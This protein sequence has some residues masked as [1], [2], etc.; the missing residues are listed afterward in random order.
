MQLLG[1]LLLLVGLQTAGQ[2]VPG[3]VVLSASRTHPYVGEVIE[4][5]L[6][7]NS[8]TSSTPLNLAIPGLTAHE[9]WRLLFDSW[10]LQSISPPKNALPLKWHGRVLYAP[11]IQPGKYE[12]RWK[13][14]IG[15]PRDEENPTRRIGP[16]Q[17]ATVTSNAL[18]L[19]IQRPPLQSPS[20]NIWDLGVGN[21]QVTA[22]WLPA[23]VVLGEEALLTISVA[24]SGAKEAIPV[25]LL[26]TQTGWESDRFLL[27][28]M[29]A[30]WKNGQR[31][32]HYLVR[33]R[34]LRAT[35]P[36]LLIR[37][38]DPLRGTTVTQAI[39]LPPLTILAAKDAGNAPLGSSLSDA[40]RH[41][42]DFRRKDIEQQT[43]V[44]WAYWLNWLLW[45]PVLWSTVVV[46]LMAL[47]RI[48]PDWLEKRRWNQ[49][50]T[51]ARRQLG[52]VTTFSA[53]QVRSILA[54]Y[55]SIGLAQPIDADWES[56]AIHAPLAP[57]PIQPILTQLQQL[58]FG[59]TDKQTIVH[60]HSAVDQAFQLQEATS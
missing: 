1:A 16:A 29:P 13:T 46:T 44:R 17:V 58:E 33:P 6:T 56:L 20:A 41:L 60:F 59:P 52:M 57:L 5:K 53:H 8:T 15:A 22:Q 4:L 18:S 51:S 31:L 27:E 25:P 43:P 36:P 19:E 28:A 50:A 37:F 47:M 10:L 23:E 38:F 40:L 32:F 2:P 34:Q 24:G 3:S 11:L 55:L 12:L 14:M 26:R 49:A 7:I 21:Y 30:R 39:S 35:T 45:I 42:P 54:S 9:S 48:A